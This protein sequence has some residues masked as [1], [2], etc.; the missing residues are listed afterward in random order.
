MLN[1]RHVDYILIL[2]WNIAAEVRSQL[3][4]QLPDTVK[5]VTAVPELRL[6]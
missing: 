1:E 3:A 2:P 4:G 5:F 6:S